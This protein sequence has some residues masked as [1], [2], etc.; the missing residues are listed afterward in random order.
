MLPNHF[1]IA[2]QLSD[3]L[4]VIMYKE[5]NNTKKYEFNVTWRVNSEPYFS[6]T[7]HTERIDM[8]IDT[9]VTFPTATDDES[10]PIHYFIANSTFP[11]PAN[12]NHANSSETVI[13]FI[14]L[15][16]NIH[17]AYEFMLE[18]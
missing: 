6:T 18:P 9:N 2:S 7:T 10:D 1:D 16:S 5:S 13:E 8:N 15:N 14:L 3:E 11:I 4:A 12:M 17:D